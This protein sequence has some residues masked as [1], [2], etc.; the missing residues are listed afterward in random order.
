[1]HGKPFMT[2][3]RMLGASLVLSA[4]AALAPATAQTR[5]CIRN[6]AGETVC[7]P[8]RTVCLTERDNPAVKCSPPDGGIVLN[9]YGKAVCGVGSCTT[10]IR[11]EPFCSKVAAGAAGNSMQS[12]P[13]CTQGC[14]PAQAALCTTLSK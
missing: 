4:C 2:L 12:E 5:D 10:D 9:R 6:L 13:V 1:M 8:A 7:P 14:E 3:A 11:G